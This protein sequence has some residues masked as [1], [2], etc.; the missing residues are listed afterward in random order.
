MP[1]DGT[2]GD[3]KQ[4]GPLAGLRV[5]E[6]ASL[7]A[8]PLMGAMLGDLGAEVVKVEPPGGDQLRILGARDN[9]PGVWTLSSRNKRMVT[10]DTTTAAGLDVLHRLTA[11]ADIVTLNHPRHRLEALGCTYEDIARRNPRAVVVNLER[12]RAD[13]SLRGPVGQWQP[14]GGVRGPVVVGQGRGGPPT[15]DP[16]PLR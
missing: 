16:G 5:L 13:R 1:A 9:R 10:V 11:V 4:G 15:L 14:G 12:V 6:L 7:F 2:E 3:P 8:G